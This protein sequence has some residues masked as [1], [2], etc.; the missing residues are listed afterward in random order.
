MT[1]KT[2]WKK[3][4]HPDYL[5]AYALN[6]GEEKTLTIKSVASELVVGTDGKKEECIVARFT[7]DEK[8]MILNKTNMK[9]IQKIYKTPYIEDWAGK[10]IT[11]YTEK[12]K[13]FGEVVEALRIRERMPKNTPPEPDVFC[14]VCGKKI[15]APLGMAVSEMVKRTQATYGKNV[16][17]ECAIK[18]KKE[19]TD[20]SEENVNENN[21]N[22]D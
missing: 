21:E 20:E 5:G 16:C 7:E 3:L 2:H 1:N 18:L 11:I 10:K 13:A 22:Q 9:T 17:M 12:V 14:E 8:P 15:V 4:T 19:K 6:P